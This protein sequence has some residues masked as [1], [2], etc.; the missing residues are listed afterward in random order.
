MRLT[1]G[2]ATFVAAAIMIHSARSSVFIEAFQSI[3]RHPAPAAARLFASTMDE[4][5]ASAI[6]TTKQSVPKKQSQQKSISDRFAAS[7]MASAAAMATAAG[8][9]VH[10]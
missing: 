7:T 1:L 2:V 3:L 10:G 9:I 5:S 4:I 6:P 8:T